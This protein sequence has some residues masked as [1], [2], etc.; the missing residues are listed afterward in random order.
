MRSGGADARI[1]LAFQSVFQGAG[2]RLGRALTFAAADVDK[3]LAA[4]ADDF[5]GPVQAYITEH[6]WGAICL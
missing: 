6:A 5:G 3:A 2:G 4:N 1:E